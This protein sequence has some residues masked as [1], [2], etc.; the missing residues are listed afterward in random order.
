M[1][2]SPLIF[3]ADPVPVVKAQRYGRGANFYRPP[4]E[5]QIERLA[6]QFATLQSAMNNGRVRIEQN[7][8][9][10]EPEYTLVLEVAGDP[11]DFKTAV[12][13]TQGIEWLF[14]VVD[15]SVPNGEDFYRLKNDQ[16]DDS[17]TMTFK[18]FCILTNQRALEEIL[19]LWQEFQKDE[20]CAFPYGQAG[21]RNV[22]RTLSDIHLW[23]VKDRL[24]ETDIIEAWEE[25]L[26]NPDISA[27]KCEV[28]LF[29]RR[30]PEKRSKALSDVSEYIQKIGGS[31]IATS[32][33]EDIGYQAIL[34]SIPRQY[35]ERIV[36]REDVELVRLD[37]IMFFK[38]T[39]QSIVLGTDDGLPFEKEFH[40]PEQIIDDPIIALF[41][42]LPQE[43]HPLLTGL[44]SIDDP[45][46]YTASYQIEDRQHGTSMASLIARGD[47]SCTLESLTSHKIYVAQL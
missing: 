39:G 34:A 10:V 32:C 37:Q 28:E 31:V 30:S 21:L 25:D 40:E 24:E 1:A 41:D 43:R 18:Y 20:N 22:F 23:G 14:E 3:F 42:G 35:A 16:R 12:R 17:K 29:F 33:I 11:S 6:P 2:N 27:V 46:D 8:D 7:P 26:L 44:L 38:P 4:H 9:A 15:N 5:R 47:L 13:N 36:S 19:S 45:D